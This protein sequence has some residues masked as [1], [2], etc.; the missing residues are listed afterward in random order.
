MIPKTIHQLWIGPK[1]PPLAWM[2]TWKQLN[3][4]WEYVFWDEKALKS[5]FTNGLRNQRQFDE[6]QEWC[7]KCDV[8][9]VEILHAVGGFFID[10]DTVCMQ[11]LDDYLLIND[12]FSCY[13]NEFARGQLVASGYM[14]ATK[15]NTLMELL[16]EQIGRLN[17]N[18][19]LAAPTSSPW[20]T[21]HQAWQLTGS[22]LITSTIF[23]NKYT[24]IS[25]YPSY[26]FI[27]E[28]YSGIKYTGPGKSYCHQL[29]GS[30][31]GSRFYGYEHSKLPIQR[32]ND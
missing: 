8:A 11:P 6:M 14:A 21:T 27:P 18:E 24:A 32:G 16:I 9:R 29:W 3:P 30:T 7:G 31:I 25:I 26:Y 4:G 23:K 19:I 28:H 1:K 15:N 10:A 20:D 2:E 5:Y 17:I 13:E 12:S 22:G